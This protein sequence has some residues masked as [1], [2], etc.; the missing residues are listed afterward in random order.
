M[1][2]LL[3]GASLQNISI[4]RKH[5]K[6][7][8]QICNTRL[9]LDCFLTVP[10]SWAFWR[11]ALF[12]QSRYIQNLGSRAYNACHVHL[13]KDTQVTLFCESRIHCGSCFSKF[14]MFPVKG[15][16]KTHEHQAIP[17]KSCTT[18]QTVQR[19]YAV[20]NTNNSYSS[21]SPREW[22]EQVKTV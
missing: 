20:I 9:S 13:I 4:P 10:L 5:K 6:T 8:S 22:Y 17:P 2:S 21:P 19:M 18:K 14:Q 12:I 1:Y 16:I 11:V 3:Y 15:S 7:M